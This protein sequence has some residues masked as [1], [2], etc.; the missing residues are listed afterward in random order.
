MDIVCNRQ[1]V[2]CSFLP[3]YTLHVL[4]CLVI[5]IGVSRDLLILFTIKAKCHGQFYDIWATKW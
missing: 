2:T 4:V 5:M 3:Q 1:Y